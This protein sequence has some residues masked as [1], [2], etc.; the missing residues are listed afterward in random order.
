MVPEAGEWLAKS[1]WG[2]PAGK[3]HLADRIVRA[4]PSHQVYVEA[5]AG[6]AQVLFAKERSEVEVLND[7]D[8]EIAFAFR[9]ARDL[10]KAQLEHL[11]K[12][13]WVG[14]RDR[15]DRLYHSDP[16]DPLDRFYRFAY[17]ARFSFNKQRRGTLPRKLQ[18]TEAR[19]VEQLEREAP[20]LDGVLVRQ[21]DY[22][23]VIDEF[24]GKETFFFLDPP[25]AG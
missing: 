15:F 8:P 20:R 22:A 14:D 6:G 9:F 3:R 17:L 16:K 21:A 4:M 19:F 11:R 5:F 12:K 1:L 10:T 25:Y 23:K 2:S 18:G 24:D 7:L 13:S